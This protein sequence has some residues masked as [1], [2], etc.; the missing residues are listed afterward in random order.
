[1][2]LIQLKNNTHDGQFVVSR[3]LIKPS[4]HNKKDQT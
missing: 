2:K 1:M 4:L 3:V